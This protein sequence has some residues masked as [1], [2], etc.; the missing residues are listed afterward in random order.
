M[1]NVL[2]LCVVAAA[3][4]FS[5]A[6]VPQTAGKLKL[7]DRASAGDATAQVEL[8]QAYTTGQGR[9]KNLSQA[10]FWYRKA[11]M[12]G[13]VNAEYNLAIYYSAGE[14]VPKNQVEATAWFLKAA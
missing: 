3:L 13:N 8:A 4:A 10:I 7:E 2:T 5:V 9:T 14:G 11:A 6:A 1:S 12:Q